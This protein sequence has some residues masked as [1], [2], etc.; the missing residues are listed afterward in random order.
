MK[1]KKWMLEKKQRNKIQI[2]FLEKAIV[3]FIHGRYE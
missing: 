2:K 3:K 1:G